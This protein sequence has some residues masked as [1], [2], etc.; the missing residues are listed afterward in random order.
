M[1]I[2]AIYLST[3]IQYSLVL[4][5]LTLSGC[6]TFGT[7][8]IT[9]PIYGQSF[10]FASLGYSQLANESLLNK[11]KPQTS[12]LYVNAMEGF[13]ANKNTKIQNHNLEKFDLISDID[14]SE[15]K[16]ICQEFKLDGFL[17]TQIKYKFFDN[18]YMVIPL[19]RSEDVYSE[20]KLFD[21]NGNVIVHTKHNTASGNSY[22]MPPKAEKTI[23]D[24]V[25]GALKQIEKELAKV[26]RRK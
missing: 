22:M 4:I 5:L 10:E 15:I 13:Y 18:Y 3:K 21:K 1:N 8:T 19:G 2:K 9:K 17:C 11:I 16:R 25:V 20:I 14:P 12:Q 23:K 26:N 6:T 24:G 7:R